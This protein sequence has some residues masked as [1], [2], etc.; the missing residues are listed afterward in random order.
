RGR[1]IRQ[2]LTE[3]V[4]LAVMGAA[5]S[6]CFGVWGMDLL[7]ALSTGGEA[8]ALDWRVL[9]FTSVVA[10]LTSIGFGLVPALRATRLNLSTE[11]QGG[12][13]KLGG[14]R[15]RLSR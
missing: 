8:P 14:G 6:T 7:S 9:G 10:L 11:F 3:S 4:L 12:M 1:L 2:L 13:R 5:L 15:S